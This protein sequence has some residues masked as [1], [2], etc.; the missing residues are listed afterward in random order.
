M[1]KIEKSTVKRLCPASKRATNYDKDDGTIPCFLPSSLLMLAVASSLLVTTQEGGEWL[2][3]PSNGERKTRKES[4][5]RL[6]H[7]TALLAESGKVGADARETRRSL[8]RTKGTRNLLLDLD[9]AQVTLRLIVGKR[10]R[11]VNPPPPE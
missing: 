9:H 4:S 10:D 7:R 3:R 6:K 11:Q 1:A 5:K 2:K 8:G